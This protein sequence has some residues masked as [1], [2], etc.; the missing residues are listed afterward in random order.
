MAPSTL[1][2]SRDSGEARA[3]TDEDVRGRKL[4]E[5]R[6][7]PRRHRRWLDNRRQAAHGA[8]LLCRVRRLP[9]GR[10]TTHVL[11]PAD[12]ITHLGVAPYWRRPL[13]EAFATETP[14]RERGLAGAVASG[15]LHLSTRSPPTQ[16]GLRGARTEEGSCLEVGRLRLPGPTGT[17]V[18]GHEAGPRRVMQ[19]AKIGHRQDNSGR[20]DMMAESSTTSDTQ[21]QQ[22]V[23]R[24]LRWDSRVEA[25]DVGVAVHH[26]VVTLTGTVDSYVTKLAAAEAAHRVAGVL[27]VANDLKVKL[28]G[29]GARTDTEIA[30]AVRQA[31]AWDPLCAG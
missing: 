23:L 25:P 15:D 21:I 16:S 13:R 12:A 22:D 29:F 4:P 18:G 31:M 20:T 9:L 27:D 30:Q 11:I 8:V 24:E 19:R 26:G 1:R 6:R 3:N 14:R 2:R 17:Q 10:G 7:E 5:Y 28:P